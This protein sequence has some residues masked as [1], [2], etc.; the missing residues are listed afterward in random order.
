MKI[1]FDQGTPVPLRNYL[2]SHEVKTAFEL[3][4]SAL[5]NGDLLKRAEELFDLMITTDQ[6]LRYQQNLSERKMAVLVLL[7]SSWPRLIKVVREICE[8]V[9][10]IEQG[11]YREISVS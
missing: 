8:T 10:S 3:G 11:E 6:Q 2:Q 5:S 9:E 4:W 7:S 1:L